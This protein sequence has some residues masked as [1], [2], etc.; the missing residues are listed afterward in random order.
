MNISIFAWDKQ[1][2]KFQRY[3]RRLVLF[4]LFY[5]VVKSFMITFNSFVEIQNLV[6]RHH[7]ML[8]Q[9]LFRKILSHLATDEATSIFNFWW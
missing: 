7:N 8:S 4:L 6:I 1:W 3:K 2:F 9:T 5:I